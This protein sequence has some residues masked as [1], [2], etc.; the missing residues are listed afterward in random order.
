MIGVAP[1]RFTGMDQYLRPTMFVPLAMA[2][3][4]ADKPGSNLLEHRGE[5]GLG[6]KGA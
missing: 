6:V 4:M 2:P 3:G 5:R 1:E